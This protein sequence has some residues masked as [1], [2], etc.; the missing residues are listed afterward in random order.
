MVMECLSAL[1][2]RTDEWSLFS[3]LG[4]CNIPHR[5]SLYADDLMVFLSPTPADLNLMKEIL[6]AY[7]GA[8]GLACNMS[9]CQ[10]APIR[11]QQDDINIIKECFPYMVSDFP[12]KYLG[13]PL[14][15]AKL[16]KTALQPILDKVADRL[17]V[18]KG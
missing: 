16:P 2:R 7:E 4:V 6:S 8:S 9:K 18:L 10:I 3:S 5:V 13:I 11:C 17:A 14:S 12:L 15:V 1:I